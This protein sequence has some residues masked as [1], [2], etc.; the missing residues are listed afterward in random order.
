VL[1]KGYG[2]AK[3]LY[4]QPLQRP[5]T[6]VDLLV[7]SADVETCRRAL[8]DLG[9]REQ[10]EADR[11]FDLEHHHAL[12]FVGP[13]GGVDLHFRPLAGFGTALAPEALLARAVPA[14]LEGHPVR[15]LAPEDELAHLAAHGTHHLFKKLVWLYDL[16]LFL[17]AYPHVDLDR[18]AD[19]SARAG[20]QVPVWFALERAARVLGAAVP[21]AWL[22]RFRP[23]RWQRALGLRVFDDERLTSAELA[24]SRVRA[25]AVRTLLSSDAGGIARASLAGAFRAARKA[26]AG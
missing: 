13:D 5:M 8:L 9:F 3:R 14:D 16:K 1:L 11:A 18:V 23:P 12:G 24:N 2:L 10:S 25:F 4:E 26:L 22:D 15:Y 7:G 19:L 21:E 6:D 17:A 20:L